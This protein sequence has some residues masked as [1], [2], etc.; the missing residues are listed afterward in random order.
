MGAVLDDVAVVEDDDAVGVLGAAG[1]VGYEDDGS[2]GG[3]FADAVV[4]G[5]LCAQV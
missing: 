1:A 4:G 2:V 5:L 3:T